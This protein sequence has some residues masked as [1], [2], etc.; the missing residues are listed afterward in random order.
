MSN[1]IQI[2]RG[3]VVPTEGGLAPYELGYVVNKY[4]KDGASVTNE[5]GGYLYIGDLDRVDNNNLVF[6]PT[7]I[8]SGFAD[9]ANVALSAEQIVDSSGDPVT[10]GSSTTPIFLNKGYFAT[11]GG[12]TISGTIEQANMLANPT[13]IKV[14]LAQTTFPDFNG[15]NDITT[16][17]MGILPIANGGT[18]ATS[19]EA[20]RTNLGLGAVATY[21]IL[22]IERGGTNATDIDTARSN[23]GIKTVATYDILPIEKGGTG[24]TNKDQARANLGAVGGFVQLASNKSLDANNSTFTITNGVDTKYKGYFVMCMFDSD[25]DKGYGSVFVPTNLLSTTATNFILSSIYSSKLFS[26]HKKNNDL[27]FTN[28]N[29]LG[30]GMKQGTMQVY[31]LA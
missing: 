1:I 27:V 17:V 7:K 8:K 3:T 26:I 23:L 20:A 21:N 22:P 18:G 6:K 24:A 2:K 11:C 4:E 9:V 25:N 28:I 14:N 31:G 5:S 13:K 16:G 19:E 15:Q 29:Y 10:I 12:A 30:G